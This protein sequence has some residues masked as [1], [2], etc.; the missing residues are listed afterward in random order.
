MS[1]KTWIYVIILVVVLSA[2][3]LFF[4]W[5]Y[6]AGKIT[7]KAETPTTTTPTFTDVP[8]N[9]WAF[10]QIEAVNQK[11]YM[12]GWDAQ[13]FK[14]TE[15]ATR[16]TVAVAVA[17]VYGKTADPTTPSFSDVSS[18]YWAY[19]QIEGLK[20]A[21]FIGGFGDGTFRPDLPADRGTVAAFVAKAHA[22][23]TVPDPG[24]IPPKFTD[25]LNVT[26]CPFYNEIQYLAVTVSPPVISG[27]GDG[28]FKPN[29]PADRQTVAVIMVKDKQLDIS[30]PPATPT[31]SDVGTDQTNYAYIEAVNTAGYMTGFP[32]TKIFRPEDFA[33]RA[34]VA[35]AMARTTSNFLDNPTPTF[36]DVAKDYWA[37]KEIEGVNKASIMTGFP[38]GTFRPDVATSGD[39]AIATRAT[40]AIVLARAKNLTLEPNGAQVFADVK[41]GDNGYA[42]INAIYKVNYTSGCGQDASGKPNFCPD[43]QIT[44]AVLAAFVYNAFIATT[45]VVFSAPPVTATP[46][47]T[48]TASSVSTGTGSGSSGTGSSAST[49]AEVPL[50]SAGILMGL[51]AVRYLLGK[52]IK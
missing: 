52:R 19:Q 12:V 26:N 41:P 16:A 7:P 39:V 4:W 21:G 50:A 29:D 31:F 36:P 33:D 9:Y 22:G 13:L 37:Y 6:N 23:G 51:F 38:D 47:P 14:P 20:A 30:N 15:G 32:A 35:V 1:Q 44:R 3:G 17:R 28:T 27:F 48:S 46:T 24:N 34:Q 25:C 49:G 11:G 42:E 10:N 8:A 5:N 43:N 45:P 2:A 18:T 40:V